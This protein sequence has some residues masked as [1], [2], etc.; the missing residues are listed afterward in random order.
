MIADDHAVQRR[1]RGHRNVNK[2]VDAAHAA[3][4]KTESAVLLVRVANWRFSRRTIQ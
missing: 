1:R 2:L 3:A 4:A